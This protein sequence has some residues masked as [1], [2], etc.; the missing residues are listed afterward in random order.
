VARRAK[1]ELAFLRAM[2]EPDAAGELFET[3]SESIPVFDAQ[4]D[5]RA[6]GRAWLM[7]GQITGGF[8]CQYAAWEDASARAARHYRRAGWSPSTV[9]G[10]LGVALYHGPTPVAD[11]IEQCESL[12]REHDGD[13]AS[14]ANIRLWLGG[15]EAMRGEFG[16]ARASVGRARSIYEELGLRTAVTDLCSQVLGAIEMLAG[17]PEQ[18][19]Q[20]LRQSCDMLLD[21]RSSRLA[22]VAGELADAIFVQGRSEEAELWTKIAREATGPEDLDAQ[23]SW[24]PVE[25]KIRADRGELDEAERL[26]RSTVQLVAQTDSLTRHANALLVLAQIVRARGRSDDASECAREALRLYEQKGNIVAAER[27]RTQL[28]EAV[29]AE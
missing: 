5:D 19:E 21:L 4:G 6:L 14:E 1:I 23:L 28:A 3:V 9:L 27:A 16:E 13:R 11:G 7:V 17:N 15:L 26:A 2:F 18:A 29:A 20:A 12:L 25:A 22:S 24:Q 10:N 8:Q